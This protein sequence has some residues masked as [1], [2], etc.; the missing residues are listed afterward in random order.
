MSNHSMG[1]CA[2]RFGVHTEAAAV[3]KRGVAVEAVQAEPGGS[4][5]AQWSVRKSLPGGGNSACKAWLLGG[6]RTL[7]KA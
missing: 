5:G 3:Q 4:L 6:W 1:G 7:C 2:L